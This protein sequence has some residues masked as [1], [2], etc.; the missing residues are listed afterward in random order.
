MICYWTPTGLQYQHVLRKY[1]LFTVS[2]HVQILPNQ[3]DICMCEYMYTEKCH[4]LWARVIVGMKVV[5]VFNLIFNC[6][7]V[8]HVQ[9]S[10]SL[11]F[12]FFTE[13]GP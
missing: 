3:I 1:S 7:H 10:H 13:M 5:S 9:V 2:L 6:A 11:I 8:L 12:N 4:E